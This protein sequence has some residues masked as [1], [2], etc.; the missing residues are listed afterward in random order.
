MDSATVVASDT[1]TT[2][3]LRIESRAKNPRKSWRSEGTRRFTTVRSSVGRRA[4]KEN[5]RERAFKERKWTAPLYQN[6][7]LLATCN[8]WSGGSETRPRILARKQAT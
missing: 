2:S 3:L 8:P 5:S 7:C 6:A 4:M 1:I